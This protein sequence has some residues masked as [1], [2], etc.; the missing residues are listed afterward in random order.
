M[1]DDY[2]SVWGTPLL[3]EGEEDGSMAALRGGRRAWERGT[4]LEWIGGPRAPSLGLVAMMAYG[5]VL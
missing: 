2:R 5:G 3:D 1:E 4:G